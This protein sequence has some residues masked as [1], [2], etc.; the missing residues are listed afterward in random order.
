MHTLFFF[1]LALTVLVAFHEFG[2]F[3]V[4][5]R[6]G[7][8][9]LRF[10]IGFG[11]VLW[12][13]QKS[14]EAT[15]FTI[16]AIP[17]GG[18]VKMADEREGPV[19]EADLPYAFNR[20]PLWV[21]SAVVAAGPLFN[22]GLAILLTWIV[23]V[24][25]ETGVRPVL[26]PVAPS[27]LAAQSGF[28]EGDEIVA[29]NQRPTA[30]WGQVW[31]ILQEL[32][33]DSGTIPVEVATA[34]G[35]HEERLIAI[36]EELAGHPDRLYQQLAFRPWEPVLPPILD[37]ILPDGA[38]LQAG[39]QSGDRLLTADGQP[40]ET[41]QQWVQYVQARPDVPIAVTVERDG[42]VLA[43]TV[44]PAKVD[45]TGKIGASVRI[46]PELL[47]NMQVEYRLGPIDAL[48]ESLRRTRDYSW[49]TLKMVGRMFSGEAALENLSGP[50]GIA[51]YAGQA[52]SM[53]WM[54]FVKFLAV[55]SISLGVLNLLPIPVLD[56]G[57]LLFF[58]VEGIKGSPLSEQTMA[59]TQRLGM[60]F[61]IFLMGLAVILDLQRLFS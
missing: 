27:S 49:L 6:L 40:V 14:P 58:L 9:V 50:I 5:R 54:P 12:R 48:T 19:D 10:S 3:W 18:Y 17:L 57:H 1:L 53:G 21:R 35:D 56:G 7:I 2:H 55:I 34:T 26:G 60:A 47:A 8:K 13:H 46:A 45:G 32:A 39:L 4:A 23:L 24:S 42:A 51:Q 44:R 30:T 29:V 22:F 33:V 31:G 11:H 43:L 16:S 38:A 52:A 25:G 28:A 37:K 41:W 61:L 36:D 15:E 20:Q 59:A